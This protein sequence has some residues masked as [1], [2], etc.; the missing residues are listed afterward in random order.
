MVGVGS[1]TKMEGIIRVN[2]KTTRW[3]GL[4]NSI[5]R[6]ESWPIKDSGLKTSSTVW[7]K[8]TT[9]IQ[10]LSKATSTT[11]ISII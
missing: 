4:A 11:Q 6:A 5:I 7:A 2:G 9:I 1:T 10:S 8:S 3:M